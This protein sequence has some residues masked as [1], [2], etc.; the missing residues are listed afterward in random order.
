MTRRRLGNKPLEADVER[1][2]VWFTAAGT[3]AGPAPNDAQ[4][5][6]LATNA[7]LVNE[8]VFTVGDGL[9]EVDAGGGSTYTVS[10]DVTDFIDT[11]YGLTEDSNNIRL[12]IGDGLAFDTGALVVDLVDAWSGLEFDSGELRVDADAEFTWTATHTHEAAIHFV[13]GMGITHAD[14]A[15]GNLLV[16]SGGAYVPGS[17]TI[18]DVSDLAYAAPGLTLGTSNVEGAAET[19]LRTDA[20]ILVFDATVPNTIEPDDAAATGVA[21]V[22]ARRDHEHGIVCEAPSANLSVS[23]SNAE[24]SSTS[25]ARADHAHGITTSSNPGGAASILATSA[26]GLLQLTRLDVAQYVGHIGDA[27]TYLNFQVDRLTV[28]AGGTDMIDVVEAG[29]DYVNFGGGLV[30]VNETANTKMTQG[31]TINQGGNDNEAVA[32]KS[33]D[34]A[35]GI[36]DWTETDT[37]ATMAKI[38]ANSGGLHLIGYK[39][40]DDV[41]YQVA[42][43]LT[44]RLGLAADTT[45]STSALGVV[46][47]AAQIKSGTGVANVGAD[48]NLMVIANGTTARFIFDA[49]GSA[50]ADVEW[51]T[52]QHHDDRVMLAD[53]EKA[54]SHQEEPEFAD[55][56][57]YDRRV[58][59]ELGL[60]HCDEKARAMLNV[61]RLSMLLVGA[62]RQA[63]ERVDV[64][65]T[66]LEMIR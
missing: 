32:L 34:V 24:G 37:Y 66:R 17:A 49:E 1:A 44:G 52:F 57:R 8:R 33:S 6:T 62:L 63:H 30:F 58:L 31:L 60:I 48:G 9:D 28:R 20:T 4:Y 11:D 13:T 54:L 22:A 26:A 53:L 55:F 65:D 46:Q 3:G 41:A 23:T 35:H 45:K 38:N 18:G 14:S 40:G 15:D 50:H 10:V 25:F 27:D 16:L 5:L 47:I 19:V 29:T 51:T 2:R 12:N 59:E 56:S 36:T 43:A 7:D 42:L 21:T 39:D 61:T 64:L